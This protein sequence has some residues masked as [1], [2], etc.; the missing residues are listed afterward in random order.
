MAEALLDLSFR[1]KKN[2][3]LRSA[4]T[5]SSCCSKKNRIFRSVSSVKNTASKS[6]VSGLALTTA[7]DVSFGAILTLTGSFMK[8]A[9]I[10]VMVSGVES[11]L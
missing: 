5:V 3:A 9:C 8:V 2:L 1:S 11:M 10:P 6:V 4:P 7:W